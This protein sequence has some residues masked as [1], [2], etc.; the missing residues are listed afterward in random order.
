MPMQLLMQG[1][2]DLVMDNSYQF[3]Q[4]D[5]HLSASWIFLDT[6]LTIN[7]FSNQSLV[8]NAVK[9][10]N[11]YMCIQCNAGYSGEIWYNPE[12]IANILSLADVSKH[13]HVHFNSAKEQALLIKKPDGLTKH[14][15]LLK[16]G[17][18]FHDT[19]TKDVPPTYGSNHG[20]MLMNTVDD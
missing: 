7:V 1:M 20:T 16:A 17:L 8:K 4:Y 15:V 12:G 11:H 5:G 9:V 10:T 19:A 14:F 13:F 3:V 18:N 2:E 6:G